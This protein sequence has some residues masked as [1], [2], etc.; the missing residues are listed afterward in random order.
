MS[1]R[2][3]EVM[4]LDGNRVLVRGEMVSLIA[5]LLIFASRFAKGAMTGV[6]PHLLESPG[7]AEL[8]VAVPVMC[9]GVMAARALTQA[10][11]NPLRQA[12]RRLMLEAES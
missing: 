6:A 12:P 2:N 5:I 10:G 11:F 7:V 9:T 8:F 3:V 1:Q 4:R